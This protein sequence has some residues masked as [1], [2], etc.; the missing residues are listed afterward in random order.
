MDTLTHALSGA[1]LGRATAGN[2][3]SADRYHLSVRARII[4]GLLVAAFPDSDFVM[5]SWGVLTYLENHRGI[6]HSIIMAPVWALLLSAVLAAMSRHCYHWRAFYLTTLLSLCIHIAGDVITAYGTMVF[7]PFSDY[8]LALPTTFIID[9]YFTGIILLALLIAIFI[10]NEGQRIAQ[11][12]LL[13][14]L[15]YI[16]YQGSQHFDALAIARDYAEQH[17]LQAQEVVAMPQF[18]SPWH[19]KLLIKTQQKYHVSY[20]HLKR[21]EEHVAVSDSLF[22]KVNVR[23][24]PAQQLEWIQHNRLNYADIPRQQIETIWQSEI[25]RPVRKFML[26]PSLEKYQQRAE[27]DCYWF[28]DHRFVIDGIRAP[29]RFAVCGQQQQWVLYRSEENHLSRLDG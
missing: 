3:T 4:T 9:F 8:K 26:Y 20:V 19:W 1:L 5:R 21:D 24:Q 27:G 25:M 2:R 22:E 28:I 16:G 23:F 11:A 7:A 15:S 29:F 14:L 18:L 10:K 17:Q 13:L 12:G 6:T